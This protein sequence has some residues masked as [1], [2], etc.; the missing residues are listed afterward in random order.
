MEGGAD[1]KQRWKK[2][3][4]HGPL[5]ITNRYDT[6]LFTI[7]GLRE[8]RKRL[9]DLRLL[10]RRDVVLFCEFGLAL[11]GCRGRDFAFRRLP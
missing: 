2:D 10:A 9:L 11:L 8:Q 3:V 6:L 4:H 5:D 7:H 1:G